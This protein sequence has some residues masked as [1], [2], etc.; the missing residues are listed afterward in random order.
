MT[1]QRSALHTIAAAAGSQFLEHHGWEVSAAYADPASEY[2]SVIT[3]AA[4]YDAS[5]AGRL[6]ATGDDARDLPTRWSTNTV[7]EVQGVVACGS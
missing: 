7:G 2:Q 1:L 6:R 5:H 3:G 4:L